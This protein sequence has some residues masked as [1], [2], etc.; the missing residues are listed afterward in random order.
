[1][2]VR[3]LDD[4]LVPR[5]D[6]GKRP[7]DQPP[8]LF[9]G[10][11]DEALWGELGAKCLYVSTVSCSCLRCPASS[12]VSSTAL[13]LL[14]DAGWRVMMPGYTLPDGLLCASSRLAAAMW[15]L[16]SAADAAWPWL[17]SRCNASPRLYVF[18]AGLVDVR[19]LLHA[20]HHAGK[21]R[22]VLFGRGTAALRLVLKMW[23]ACNSGRH[24]LPV[25]Q[26][27]SP[28]TCS[29]ALPKLVA[30]SHIPTPIPTLLSPLHFPAF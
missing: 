22:A 25:A 18:P 15:R 28:P 13:A 23:A 10:P 6:K 30:R 9:R 4:A 29:V 19:G 14:L 21:P 27:L 24:H 1:M 17:A 2:L 11:A 20:P 5:K 3:D 26:H 7:G 8:E 16:C 12:T